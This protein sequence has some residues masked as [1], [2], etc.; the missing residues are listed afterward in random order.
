[1]LAAP[2]VKLKSTI[3]SQY[4]KSGSVFYT[5]VMMRFQLNCWKMTLPWLLLHSLFNRCFMSGNVSLAWSKVIT[6]VPKSSNIDAQDPL[7]YRGI[8]L[9]PYIVVSW[10]TG[11]HSGVLTMTS[12]MMTQM[13][14]VKVEALLPRFNLW[15]QLLKIENLKHFPLLQPLLILKLEGESLWFK[16]QHLGLKPIRT[17]ML[18]SSEWI[19]YTLVWY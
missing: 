5:Y 12:F 16:L 11:W 1:M 15:L 14:S 9:A 13:D 3:Y 4:M 8:T 2:R 10:I 7:S 19:R 18:R 17:W 6:P